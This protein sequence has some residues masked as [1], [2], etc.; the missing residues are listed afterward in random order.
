MDYLQCFD[1]AGI[2]F[3]PLEN[4]DRPD[5]LSV[6]LREVVA[7]MRLVKNRDDVEFDMNEW[8]TLNGEEQCV[9]CAAGAYVLAHC[10]PNGIENV[11]YC[12]KDKIADYIIVAEP[13]DFKWAIDSFR[14]GTI[15]RYFAQQ[16]D[17]SESLIC[18]LVVL[19]DSMAERYAYNDEDY[20]DVV[21]WFNTAATFLESRGY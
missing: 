14:T 18:D 12:V 20:T 4:I 15:S 5:K 6:L 13:D 9:V 8:A 21:K 3:E 17:L 16:Y 1:D 19:F 7:D 2:L 11:P 10:F